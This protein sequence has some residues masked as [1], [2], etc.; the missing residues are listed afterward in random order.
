MQRSAHAMRRRE[1]DSSAAAW[2]GLLFVAC[3]LFALVLA[4]GCTRRFFRQDADEE[5]A[6]LLEEKGNPVQWP[7][8][9]YWIYPHPYARFADLTGNPDFPPMPPD[10][11]AAWELSPHP[12]KPKW[13]AELSGTGYLD[14]LEQ[15]DT[16]NRELRKQ[17][18]VQEGI[19]SAVASVIN[20]NP[21]QKAPGM[22][23]EEK[24]LVGQTWPRWNRDKPYLLNLDQCLELAVV[25][26]REFQ[27]RRENVYLAALPVTLQRFNFLPQFLATQNAVRQWSGAGSPEG[28]SNTGTINS[29]VGFTQL[30]STG[31][32]LV[33]RI[34]NQTV[35]DFSSNK[36][37]TLSQSTAVLDLTQPFLRGG[38]FAVTLEPLT[39]AER[40]LLYEMRSYNRFTREFYVN[41]A[42]GQQ[43]TVGGGGGGDFGGLGLD[44]A[45]AGAARAVGYY[46]TLR[47]LMAVQ[48][49]R[50][51]VES[52]ESL[53]KFFQ[54]F[55]EGGGYSKLQVDQ[56]EQDLNSAKLTLLQAEITY[57]DNLDQF[58]I[59]LGIPTDLPIELDLAALEPITK[60]I[61][62]Y[63]KL[64]T[65]FRQVLVD[66]EQLESA[67]DA[68]ARIRG[69]IRK[70]IRESALTQDTAFKA[71]F[72]DRFDRWQALND[73]SGVAAGRLGDLT[74]LLL[75][76]P[77]QGTSAAIPG[78]FVPRQSKMLEML[79]EM[80]QRRQKLLDA[81]DEADN[82]GKP[83]PAESLAE[84]QQL[85][86]SVDHAELELVLSVFEQT[87]FADAGADA[88]ARQLRRDLYRRILYR[89]ALLLEEARVE[90]L[91]ILESEW[92]ELP[93]VRLNE[94]DLLDVPLEEAQTLAGDVALRNRLDLMNR[95]AEVVDS[96]R[97]IAVFAN[98]LM[99][100][101]DVRYNANV[102]TPP[103]TVG[104]PVNFKGSN[105]T[106][107]LI[108]NT[109]LPLVRQFERNQYRA[110]LIAFQRQRR[111]LQST[112]DQILF[113]VRQSIRQLRQ[114][115]EQFKIQQRNLQLS[116][117][118]VDNALEVLRA[119]PAPGEQRDAATAAAALTDQL[120]RA[121][122]SVP[123]AQ[124]G[125]YQTWVNFL[126]TRMRLYRDLELLQIDTR[127]VWINDAPANGDP[128]ESLQQPGREPADG[129]TGQPN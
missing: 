2:P 118:R 1:R 52:L 92:P 49:E 9:D 79:E 30:F 66:L 101:F 83:F 115:E 121:Q 35:I 120:L 122:Q 81:K 29:N 54:A 48:V 119:P 68:S 43:I 88:R 50:S 89:F 7:L 91:K 24:P 128:D 8:I 17:S 27:S 108:F 74:G 113:Q 95:R 67:P 123:R 87:S 124:N 59:Q 129:G 106:H 78:V 126:T 12:Q 93:A 36:G 97:K 20:Q 70:L 42:G 127:G 77:G 94:A 55:A 86:I 11:P 65:Q 62:A 44:L 57:Q 53:F 4:P 96:W 112:E 16:A 125:L 109:E 46:P 72:L 22:E 98:S 5:V 75:A 100:T 102:F 37:P 47:N 28:R 71:E 25:N 60:Q 103:L 13:I 56:V 38:G 51:N 23:P 110:S 82:Q 64:E 80:R 117:Y 114:L 76:A 34:A 3:L 18:P 6:A 14:L 105:A 10:D 104:Q 15:Y 26:S 45:V 111:N 116:L 73:P 90:R 40:D 58:K 107:Q 85:T 21:D 69:F 61:R 33:L 31:A 41:I 99:G 32:L 84:L 63:Q 39:Q 19:P